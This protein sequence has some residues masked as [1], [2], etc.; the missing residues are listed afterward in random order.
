MTQENELL[1]V[2]YK[3]TNNAMVNGQMRPDQ[4]NTVKL[5]IIFKAC[6]H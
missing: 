2:F 5:F 4:L 1:N 3:D 6:R